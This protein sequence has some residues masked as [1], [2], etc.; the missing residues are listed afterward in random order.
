MIA[1]PCSAQHGP[2]VEFVR[3]WRQWKAML[4]AGDGVP[5]HEF[6]G[7]EE[8]DEDAAVAAV[9]R[10]PTV[11]P[12]DGRRGER[13]IVGGE[14]EARVGGYGLDVVDEAKQVRCSIEFVVA[15][16]E[17]GVGEEAAPWL[18][19]EGGADETKEMFMLMDRTLIWFNVEGI[20]EVQ[21]LGC[22]PDEA[23]P[24]GPV[25]PPLRSHCA[26]VEFLLW[27]KYDSEC[28]CY[29]FQWID[30]QD[31]YDPRIRLFPYDEKELKPYNEFRMDGLCVTFRSIYM[32]RSLF[33]RW[34]R[35]CGCSR[36]ENALALREKA[37]SPLREERV[38]GRIF[39]DV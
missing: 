14:D 28:P 16:E 7:I 9:E 20:F 26:Y 29:F 38:I 15:A 13:R 35:R 31:K 36:R 23:W 32:V 39:Q 27:D 6:H 24:E 22:Y 4:V 30:G 34:M 10:Q 17:G 5:D 18:A 3:L 25:P 8:V 21:G 12:V 33:G 37:P 19:D 2:R 1:V 11:V